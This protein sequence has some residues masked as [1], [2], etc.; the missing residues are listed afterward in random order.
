MAKILPLTFLALILSTVI[1]IG[2]ASPIPVI[3]QTDPTTTVFLDPQTIYGTVIGQEFNV[4]IMIR[5]ANSIYSWEAGLAF[6]ATLLNCTGLFE[7]EF[8][9]S[10]GG[11]YWVKGTVNNTLEMVRPPCFCT[12]LGDKVASGD[13]QLA[14][15]TFKVEALGVSDIHLS[16]V[17]VF[18]YNLHV[19]PINIIDVYTVIVGTTSNTVVTVSNLTG[20]S[21]EYA[22]RFYDHAFNPTLNETSF[23]TAGPNAITPNIPEVSASFC[24]VT[25]PKALLPAPTPPHVWAVLINGT[26]LSTGE[27]TVTENATHTSIYFTFPPGINDVQITTL[28][29]S[30]TI[31]MSLSETSI[32]LGSSLTISGAISPV[33]PNKT[34]TVYNRIKGATTWNTLANVTTNQNGV[35]TRT[36]KP[37]KKGTYEVMASWKGDNKTLPAGSGVLTLDV[38]VKGGVPLLD[39]VAIVVVAIIVIAAIVVYFV[40]IRKPKPQ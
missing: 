26:A 2:T 19:I 15:A 10:V 14:Y 24:N 27:I 38:T 30:S 34:V 6:N 22:I 7:G 11:T 36:W 3:N 13:G 35:Y 12:L 25:I 29:M 31:S 16:D 4:S 17:E 28:F 39:V 18:D 37:G 20:S 9:K 1:L 32:S 23:K 40:K 5:N 21:Q 33:R 8:L